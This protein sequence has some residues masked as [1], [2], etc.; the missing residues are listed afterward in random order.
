MVYNAAGLKAGYQADEATMREWAAWKADRKASAPIVR[1]GTK[2]ATR[3]SVDALEDGVGK[4]AGQR[5]SVD[6]AVEDIYGPRLFTIDE[7]NWG[8]LEGEIL[9]YMPSAAAL[10]I[11]DDDR[12]TVTGEVRKFVLADASARSMRRIAKT[13]G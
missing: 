3:V 2:D 4:F 1:A 10:S 7:P 9:V 11:R 8:D 5:V 6:G 13:T 12:V